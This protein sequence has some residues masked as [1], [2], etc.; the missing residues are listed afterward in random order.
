MDVR[1]IWSGIFEYWSDLWSRRAKGAM[2]KSRMQNKIEGRGSISKY[3]RIEYWSP[4]FDFMAHLKTK[5]HFVFKKK[6]D[7]Y[8]EGW[9]KLYL[10]SHVILTVPYQINNQGLY[11]LQIALYLAI[12]MIVRFFSHLLIICG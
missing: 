10:F 12:N 8:L 3:P 2:I 6:Q 1:N 11:A 4:K 9:S 5:T 7:T